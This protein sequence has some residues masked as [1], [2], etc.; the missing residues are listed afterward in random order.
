MQRLTNFDD[1][2]FNMLFESSKMPM[3]FKLSRRLT[4][5]IETINSPIS[6]EI[7]E[8]AAYSPAKEIT[9][10][11]YDETDINKFTY[12]L[13]NKLFDFISTKHSKEDHYSVQK[14]ANLYY[15]QGGDSEIWNVHRTSSRI[16]AFVNKI[17]PKKYTEKEVESFVNAVKAKRTQQFERFKI[18]KGSDIPKYYLESNYDSRADE[19]TPLG[20]SCMRYNKCE[21]YMDFYVQNN[22]EMVVLMSDDDDQKDKIA[23]RAILWTIKNIDGESVDRKFMD[24]IYT[25]SEY[26]TQSFKDYATK[27]GW[28]Y[29]K[30]QNRY[31]NESICDP[32]NGGNCK[33]ITMITSNTYKKTKYFPYLDTMC[34]FYWQDGYLSNEGELVDDRSEQPYFLQNAQGA[35]SL[36]G[37]R[38]VAH[39]GELI[40]ED[41]LTWCELGN[42]WRY[43]SDAIAMDGEYATQEYLNNNDYVRSQIMDEWLNPNDDDVIHL[44]TYDDYVTQ[45]YADRY[46]RYSEHDEQ[47]YL[48]DDTV[49]SDYYDSYLYGNDCIEVIHNG[50]NRDWR[51]KDDN[52]YIKYINNNSYS[53][54]TQY[55][56]KDDFSNEFVDCINPKSYSGKSFKH[57]EWDADKIKEYDDVYYFDMTEEEIKKYIKLHK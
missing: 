45:T 16:G 55:Y 39:Y 42:D 32:I 37:M 10:V 8:I 30:G 53:R 31:P 21:K 51:I 2:L 19:R 20:N 34:F 11:D 25:I 52:T 12:I 26:D 28:L 36:Q 13:S 18:V 33:P 6:R 56:D 54:Q 46:M 27:N 17:F 43:H 35:Y 4:R 1:F 14:L 48:S 50:N 24:R 23:G 38:Y 15:N 49:W 5:L 40:S 44:N 9:F 57:K 7:L 3:A 47:Y 29:K 41:D 22:I